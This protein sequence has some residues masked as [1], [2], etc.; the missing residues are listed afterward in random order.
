ME[1]P[2][3]RVRIMFQGASPGESA[4]PPPGHLLL[5]EFGTAPLVRSWIKS[6]CDLWNRACCAGADSLLYRCMSDNWALRADATSCVKVWCIQWLRILQHIDF[7]VTHLADNQGNN[8][9]LA[10]IDAAEVVSV[11]NVWFLSKWPDD[12]RCADSQKV[13]T[14]VYGRWC[15]PQ[16]MSACE[17]D[18]RYESCLTYSERTAGIHPSYVGS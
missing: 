9:H 11:F 10:Q 1:Y 13:L 18:D 12:P 2:L 6:A 8:S 4:N 15:A 16:R 14:C 17:A 5:L 3:Q 7:D